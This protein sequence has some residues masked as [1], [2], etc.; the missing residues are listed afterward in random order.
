MIALPKDNPPPGK[1]KVDLKA[2]AAMF[3]IGMSMASYLYYRNWL[4]KTCQHVAFTPKVLQDVDL[5]RKMIHAV[6]SGLGIAIVPEHLRKLEHENV[7]FRPLDTVIMTEGGVASEE[8]ESFR[9]VAR[10]RAN[11]RKSWQRASVD[12]RDC[13]PRK[14]SSF[15]P[16]WCAVQG[17]NLRP[18][19][20][21]GN[22][23]PLS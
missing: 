1:A 17:S 23:L 10:G 15:C 22:A 12:L 16:Q 7:V 2:L 5:E 18:L 20:C 14:F 21:Q 9:S 4:V 3:F 8:R 19:P 11:H 13:R 6:A